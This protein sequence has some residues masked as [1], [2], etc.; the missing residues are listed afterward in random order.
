[1][2]FIL[3]LISYEFVGIF[4]TIFWPDW[5]RLLLTE[6]FWFAIFGALD[7]WCPVIPLLEFMVG[8]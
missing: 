1:M 3:F 7:F 2:A 4:W 8:S 6:S 5:L